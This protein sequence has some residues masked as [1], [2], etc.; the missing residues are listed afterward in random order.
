M[1]AV[2]KIM[3]LTLVSAVGKG[4]DG[5]E[6][7]AD[8]FRWGLARGK[9]VRVC[10]A[11]RAAVQ[12]DNDQN[13]KNAAKPQRFFPRLSYFRICRVINKSQLIPNYALSTPNCLGPR[14]PV[15]QAS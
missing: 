9:I 14:G 7:V 6:L 10:G 3:A 8:W 15:G 1:A 4:R 11:E 12:L 2:G 5:K 13:Q